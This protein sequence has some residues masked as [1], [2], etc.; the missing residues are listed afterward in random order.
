MGSP[1][2]L[3][4]SSKHVGKLLMLRARLRWL[5]RSRADALLTAHSRRPP[6]CSRWHQRQQLQSP[7]QLHPAHSLPTPCVHLQ[8]LTRLHPPG[9]AC[10]QRERE[11]YARACA[12]RARCNCM[13]PAS[14]FGGVDRVG[15]GV[16]GVGIVARFSELVLFSL[17]Q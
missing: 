4:F 2:R 5:P 15:V 10:G 7:K 12:A 6:P 17:S 14:R 1:L 16:G 13:Y 8:R 3:H 9:Q 11:R